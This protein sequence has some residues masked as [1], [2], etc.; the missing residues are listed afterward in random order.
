MEFRPEL[1]E[2]ETSRATPEEIATLFNPNDIAAYRKQHASK[3][4]PCPP[5]SRAQ[6]IANWFR[7]LFA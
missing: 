5:P 2:R 1:V 3:F 6:R 7:R 4:K